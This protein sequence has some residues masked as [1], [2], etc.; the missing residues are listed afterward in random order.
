MLLK[1]EAKKRKVLIN[2]KLLKNYTTSEGK[3]IFIAPDMSKEEREEQKLLREKKK[4]RQKN[5]EQN[6]Q[7]RGDKL[8]QKTLKH[9]DV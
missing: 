7:D 5:G 8:E 4:R 9:F 6:L 3:R 2:A 1:S